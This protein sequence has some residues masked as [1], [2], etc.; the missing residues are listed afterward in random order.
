MISKIVDSLFTLL[1]IIAH[2]SHYPDG[3]LRYSKIS[4]LV[5]ATFT[6]WWLW[7]AFQVAKLIK[8]HHGRNVK[9]LFKTFEAFLSNFCLYKEHFYPNHSLY[10]FQP[11]YIQ[12]LAGY[13]RLNVSDV[14]GKKGGLLQRILNQFQI[15]W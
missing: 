14:N 13:S 4:R 7:V 9:V 8:I 12:N 15:C 6:W 2:F 5:F 3:R 1:Q 10:E 11:N